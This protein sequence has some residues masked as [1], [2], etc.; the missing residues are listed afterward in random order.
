MKRSHILCC[1]NV[2]F[3]MDPDGVLRIEFHKDDKIEAKV[4]AD[5]VRELTRWLSGFSKETFD[6]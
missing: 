1:V 4:L 3:R 5:E 2:L 6:E